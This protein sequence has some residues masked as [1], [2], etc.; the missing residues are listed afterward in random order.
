[1]AFPILSGT[2]ARQVAGQPPPEGA[3]TPVRTGE[4]EGHDSPL[5]GLI[6]NIH[7][8]GRL[9]RN[10]LQNLLDCL[11]RSPITMT[12][13]SQIDGLLRGLSRDNIEGDADQV[14][15][16]VVGIKNPLVKEYGYQENYRNDSNHPMLV[17][18]RSDD[19]IR[20][21]GS[22]TVRNLYKD[23]V[24]M[25]RDGHAGAIGIH[26]TGPTTVLAYL[27]ANRSKPGFELRD[28]MTI[29]LAGMGINRKMG[30]KESPE[31]YAQRMLSGYMKI[32]SFLKDEA[33]SQGKQIRVLISGLQPQ[34]G[35]P[36]KNQAIQL[37]NK[38]LRTDPR[39]KDHYQPF[40]DL[41]PL[42]TDPGG[43]WK[44]GAA[45]KDGKHINPEILRGF[46]RNVLDKAHENRP[47]P[48]RGMGR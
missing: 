20:F 26:G 36:K 24:P 46:I 16:N 7:A 21:V 15:C 48:A 39:F 17:A 29:V 33:K 47:Q 5:A 3:T 27:Q 8:K 31:Q 42:V 35:D 14:L 12:E 32:V 19:R 18:V 37:F 34:P 11:L 13:Q 1:M 4:P 38:V 2:G 30:D 6:D 40:A 9:T 45:E 25:L 22:S 43:R 28:G 10:D 41:S 44:P 23:N